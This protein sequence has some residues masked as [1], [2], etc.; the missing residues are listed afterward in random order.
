MLDAPDGPV[1]PDRYPLETAGIV[2]LAS[3]A[4]AAALACW[5]AWFAARALG[6]RAHAAPRRTRDEE[7]GDEHADGNGFARPRPAPGVEGLAVA[8]AVWVCAVAALA[9]LLNPYA[10]ALIVPAAHLWLLAASGWRGWAAAVA[11]ALGLVA[12]ALVFV[13]YG[14]ALGLGPLGLAWGAALGAAAGAGFGSA[15]LFAGLLAAFAGTVRVVLARR[16][17]AREQNSA[18][19][20]IRTRGPVTYAGPGSLGGTESALRR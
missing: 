7:P 3:A 19:A 20:P 12:P 10:A 13:H 15:L 6:R 18:G 1:M 9:W 17:I 8:T 4:L 14:L 11:L 5:G 16:R 2:A